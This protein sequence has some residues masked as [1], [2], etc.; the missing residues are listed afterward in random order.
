MAKRDELHI[1]LRKLDP[2]KAEKRPWGSFTTLYSDHGHE[3]KTDR[4]EFKAKLIVVNPGQR[5]SLQKHTL[6]SEVWVVLSGVGT[7]TVGSEHIH[8]SEMELLIIP[9]GMRHRVKND[10]QSFPLVLAEVQVGLCEED[11]IQRFE[12]DYGRS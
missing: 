6:R 10:S 1:D 12:D 7:A 4:P 3:S 9:K 11:D 8:L 5:L 2:K